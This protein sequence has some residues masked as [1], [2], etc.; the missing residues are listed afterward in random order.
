[1]ESSLLHRRMKLPYHY[2]RSDF[3]IQVK[4]KKLDNGHQQITYILGF[5]EWLKVLWKA[6][7]TVDIWSSKT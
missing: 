5:K 4:C 2:Q 7:F 3:M 1:M 6:E